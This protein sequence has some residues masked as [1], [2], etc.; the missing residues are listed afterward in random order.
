MNHL[1]QQSMPSE[2]VKKTQNITSK[3]IIYLCYQT[4]Y[5]ISQVPKMIIQAF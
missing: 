3:Q 5:S 4:V 1:L 2:F